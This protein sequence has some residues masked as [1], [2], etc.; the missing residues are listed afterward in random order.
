MI[1]SGAWRAGQIVREFVFVS[2]CADL[3]AHGLGARP[4]RR[5]RIK[6]ALAASRAQLRRQRPS[7]S[8]IAGETAR[9]RGVPD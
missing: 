1:F 6:L 7:A 2:V 3:S 4:N 8:R 9:P 5:A